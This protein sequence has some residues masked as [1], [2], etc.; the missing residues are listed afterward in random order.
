MQKL[1]IICEEIAATAKK[2]VKTTLVADF[3]KSR[4][5][6]EAAI[7]AVF[8]S[9]R[10]FPA[11]EET[12]LQVGGR[13]LWRVVADLAGKGEGELTDSYR[14]HGDL[15]AVTGEVLPQK[16]APQLGVLE[17]EKAFRQIAAAR[18]PAAKSALIR[19]LLGRATPLEAK[20]IVKIMTGDL[21]I[22]LA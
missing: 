3:L 8:L 21:R 14:K 17:V 16:A 4:P 19:D 2:L 15:G 13:L 9:G 7:S 22:G 1:A 12:T 18:G 11:R 10:P 5:V 20:Y 6:D